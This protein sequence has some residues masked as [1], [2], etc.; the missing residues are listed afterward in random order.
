MNFLKNLTINKFVI[1][2]LSFFGL[3]LVF[4]LC[5]LKAKIVNLQN[6]NTLLLSKKELCDMALKHQNDKIKALELDL[7]K[8]NENAEKISQIRKIYIKD[9]SCETELRAY[10]EL[11]K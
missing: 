2:L 9:K 11:F 6:E 5:L 10:K 4:Q 7:T 8:E 1:L 3:V